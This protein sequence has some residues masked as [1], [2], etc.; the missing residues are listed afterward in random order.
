MVHALR[1][2]RREQPLGARQTAG[3]GG[4]EHRGQFV[5]ACRQGLRWDDFVDQAQLLSLGSGQ[6]ASGE[7][8][9]ASSFVPDLPGQEYG[10][11]CRQKT[12][13]HLGVTKRGVRRGQGEIAQRGDPAAARQRRS[14]HRGDQRL[15]K[16]PDAAKHFRHAPRILLI[17]LSGLPGDG[18]EHLQIHARAE[19]FASTG[20]NGHAHLAALNFVQH[21][22]NV[23]HHLRGDGVALL[24]AIQRNGGNLTFGLQQQ[25]GVQG[26]PFNSPARRARILRGARWS[27]PKPS[28]D[29][30]R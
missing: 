26:A 18:R 12:D 8:E 13:A 29:G 17:F 15:R 22:E 14:L 23:R 11:Q 25:R 30:S 3:A 2:R 27:W 5:R 28:R 9:I 16:A 20:Q 10:Y 4:D 6:F 7:Q 1:R 24:R 21:R 19:R